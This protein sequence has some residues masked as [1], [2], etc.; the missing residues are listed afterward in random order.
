MVERRG[1]TGLSASDIRFLNFRSGYTSFTSCSPS[2]T[3]GSCVA[4][5]TNG[6]YSATTDGKFLYDGGH[7]QQHASL[8]GLDA[9]DNGTLAAEMETQ[10][11]TDVDIAYSQPQ[12]AG[13]VRT[14]PATCSGALGTPVPLTE[15]WSYSLGHWVETDPAVGDGAFSSAGAFALL[16]VGRCRQT[17][18][19][20]RGA[21][22]PAIRQR[23]RLGILRPA[24]PQGVAD[25]CSPVGDSGSRRPLE[26]RSMS[27]S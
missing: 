7:M 26:S 9:L 25:G 6:V 19:R 8:M 23:F 24:D 10:L 3:V 5:S 21:S 11:G 2:Q 15:S 13:G 16:P 20:H 12:L 22:G 17:L 4:A 14:N 27:K 18:L 1:A